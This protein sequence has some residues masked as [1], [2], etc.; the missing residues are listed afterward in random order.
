MYVS[1]Q[2]LSTQARQENDATESQGL[3]KDHF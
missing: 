1:N 2:R 3:K